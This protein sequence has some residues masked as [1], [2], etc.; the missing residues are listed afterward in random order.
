MNDTT[1]TRLRDLWTLRDFLRD[2]PGGFTT[3][4]RTKIRQL[5]RELRD[6]GIDTETRPV[7]AERT[8]WVIFTSRGRD[9][10][11][12][13]Q[14]THADRDCHVCEQYP[15]FVREATAEEIK[16]LRRCGFCG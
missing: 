10:L 4:T 2:N 6:D 12:G 15:G 8:R 13:A 3:V 11:G 1:D 7:Q 16:R 9:D 14:T 5:E